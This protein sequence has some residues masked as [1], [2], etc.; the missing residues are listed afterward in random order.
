MRLK[1]LFKLEFNRSLNTWL[2]D[3][4]TNLNKTSGRDFWKKYQRFIVLRNKTTLGAL[5][6]HEGKHVSFAEDRIEVLK[7]CFFTGEHLKSQNFCEIDRLQDVITKTKLLSK[8]ALDEKSGVLNEP[9]TLNETEIALKNPK[10]VCKVFDPDGFHPKLIKH[11]GARFRLI[12][13]HFFAKSLECKKRVWR[14]RKVIFLPKNGKKVDLEAKSF[15]PITLLSVIGKLFESIIAAR[16]SWILTRNNA[17]DDNQEGFRSGRGTLR[18]LYKIFSDINGIN[19]QTRRAVLVRID[20]EKAFDSVDVNLMTIKFINAGVVGKLARLIHDYLSS[21]AI[22]IQIDDTVSPQ[23][24]CELGLPQRSILSPLLFII[25]I[26]DIVSDPTLTHYKYADDTTL[27]VESNTA[28]DSLLKASE[29]IEQVTTWCFR[30][31][32]MINVSKTVFLLINSSKEEL[33]QTQN[34]THKGTK[35]VKERL[36]VTGIEIGAINETIMT[37]TREG[38]AEWAK[39]KQFCQITNGLNC[40]TI[41]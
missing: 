8:I 18:M 6:N 39:L 15:R 2:Q 13:Q 36:T 27:F 4:L 29:A 23:F 35:V 34:F 21:R 17:L 37:A 3:N 28:S 30:N 1:E 25:F 12:L 19:Y 5:K 10:I 26:I 16:I 20:L 14:E 38:W 9:I 31:R 11:S 33:E 40:K 7:R 41:I 32:I 22:R 24:S